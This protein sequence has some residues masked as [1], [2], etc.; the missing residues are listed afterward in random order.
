[1]KKI[2]FVLILFLLLVQSSCQ[3]K[4][5]IIGL[6]IESQYTIERMKLLILHPQYEAEAYR[7]TQLDANGSDSLISSQRDLY[8]CTATP[9]DY[10]VRLQL[11]DSLNPYVHEVHIKVWEEE[12][13]YSPYISEVYEYRPAPGQF[14][15]KMPAYE[16]GDSEETML[17]KVRE[18][19]VGTQNTLISLGSYGG[20]VTF[21]FDH[22]LVN[23][24]GKLD[25]AIYGNAYYDTS[26]DRLGG[27]SEPGIVMVAMDVNGNGS[28]DDPWYEL[29]GSEYDNE[30]T[31]HQYEVVY[32]RHDTLAVDTLRHKGVLWKDSNGQCGYLQKNSYH[33]QN[34]FPSWID[35]DTLLYRGTRLP[36][37]AED[38]YGNGSRWVLYAYDWGYADA[39]PN[40]KLDKISFDIN[41]AVDENG[42]RVYLPGIHF[43]RVY[44]GVLQVCGWLGETSTELSKAVDLNL[45][46]E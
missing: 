24:P 22:C 28:P 38:Y 27:S 13:A 3:P 12:V 41:W 15:N 34:Y 31:M 32:Y 20:Y 18:C 6:G 5:E 39:H 36:D 40:N 14:V 1:M 33:S 46:E 11:I 10:T 8:F 26:L 17:Q 16:E 35:S 2:Q 21:G 23:M 29:A 25:F 9:G 43:V 19:I 4:P 37:N 30:N 7:W 44:T 45:L 42:K